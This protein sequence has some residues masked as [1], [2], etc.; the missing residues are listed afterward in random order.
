MLAACPQFAKIADAL[1]D[2]PDMLPKEG[3]L[4]SRLF[5]ALH[6]QGKSN[7]SETFVHKNANIDISGNLLQVECKRR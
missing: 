5:Q 4:N 7:A 2:W 3:F 6:L 1:A